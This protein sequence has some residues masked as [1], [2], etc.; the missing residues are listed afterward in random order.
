[1]SLTTIREQI[2]TILSAV[3]GIGVVHDY[4]RWS[5]SWGKFLELFL[6]END[7]NKKIINGCMFTRTST[8]EKWL[9]NVKYLRVYEFLFR[10]VYGLKDADATELIFQDLI[11]DICA[12]FRS[13]HT[14]N[15]TC[16]TIA[17]EFGALSGRS[18]IQVEIVQN[19][20]FGTVLAH[21]FELR[22]G[23]QVT[24]TKA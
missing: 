16:E 6:V 20:M 11:E 22:L 14:L 24:E 8:P 3:D 7:D 13:N 23:A 21:F 1:M 15:G 17:P 2:K 10:G 18:G 19:R 5:A 9:T 4:E 12:A